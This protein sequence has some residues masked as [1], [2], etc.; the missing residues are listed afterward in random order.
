M[1]PPPR[2]YQGHQYSY[3]STVPSLS[4]TASSRV[5]SA[6]STVPSSNGAAGSENW[7]TFGSDDEEQAERFSMDP[8]AH[9]PSQTFKRVYPDDI[10]GNTAGKKMRAL[11]GDYT[12]TAERHVAVSGSESGWMDDDVGS[13]F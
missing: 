5:A 13:V 12:S 4:N 9:F 6:D 11:R 2:P 3:S 10:D 1:P 7:E 8:R